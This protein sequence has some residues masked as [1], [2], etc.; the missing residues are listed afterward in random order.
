MKNKIYA[1]LSVLAVVSVI[2]GLVWIGVAQWQDNQANQAEAAAAETNRRELERLLEATTTTV[3]PTTTTEVA[4]TLP[5]VTT[6]TSAAPATST[7]V[8]PTTT[9]IP[10]P[11]PP[12]RDSIGTNAV[13][14]GLSVPAI[15]LD[16]TIARAEERTH[17]HEALKGGT[18]WFPSSST[19]VD[20][21]LGTDDLD[22]PGQGGNVAIG[23]HRG[24]SGRSGVFGQIDRLALGDEVVVTTAWGVFTYRVTVPCHD[25]DQSKC[26]LRDTEILGHFAQAESSV[27]TLFL[28]SCD[29]GMR[30]FVTAELVSAEVV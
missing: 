25:G 5:R 2:A 15:G 4:T 30:I 22:L 7:T 29:D 9:T 23:G 10:L 6:T 27:E 19:W 12:A 26:A 8:P 14:G 3:P 20:T 17:G 1:L 28:F 13:F 18:A 16:Q 21:G 11:V 24:G